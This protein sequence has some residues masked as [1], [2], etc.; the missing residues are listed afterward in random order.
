[1]Q[2]VLNDGGDLYYCDTDSIFA[3]YETQK[4]N[5]SLGEIK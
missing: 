3:G 1:M 4:L 2:D 5:Q